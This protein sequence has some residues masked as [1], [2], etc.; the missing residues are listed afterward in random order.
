MGEVSARACTFIPQRTQ[1][2]LDGLNSWQKRVWHHFYPGGNW[3]QLSGGKQNPLELKSENT[4]FS[5]AG[6]IL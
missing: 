5:T 6:D 1:G 3:P 2:N 4:I